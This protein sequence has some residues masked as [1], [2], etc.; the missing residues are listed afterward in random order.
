M[1]VQWSRESWTNAESWYHMVT[2]DEVRDAMRGIQEW[3]KLQ[4]ESKASGSVKPNLP[5]TGPLLERIGGH[6]AV[7]RVVEAFCRKLYADE[8]LVPFLQGRDIVYMRA[9]LSNFTTWLFGPSHLP[10]TGKHMRNAHLR[11]I[12]ERGFTP[13]HFERGIAYF[14]E[15]NLVNEA[16]AKLRPFK[17]VVFTATSR[18]AEEEARWAAEERSKELQ[19]RLKEQREL[20]ER[21]ER[22]AK[23]RQ[24]QEQ[25]EQQEK[26]ARQQWEKEWEQEAQQDERTKEQPPGKPQTGQLSPPPQQ[27]Q[28]QQHSVQPPPLPPLL[29]AAPGSPLV[30]GTASAGSRDQASP[31]GGYATPFTPMESPGKAPSSWVAD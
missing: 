14:H 29:A 15:A 22:E 4:E 26:Q 3:E 6:D 25:R 8:R 9:K 13:E 20:Q 30:V 31:S 10:Y 19:R 5:T 23:E 7:K 2:K 28:Q 18:D 27:P 1:G 12:K 16:L 24:E 11:L 21:R 17:G